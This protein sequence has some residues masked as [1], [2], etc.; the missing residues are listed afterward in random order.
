MENPQAAPRGGERGVC[1]AKSSASTSLS[2]LQPLQVP[3]G[4]EEPSFPS[5]GATALCAQEAE[6][7]NEALTKM[8]VQGKKHGPARPQLKQGASCSSQQP[9]AQGRAFARGLPLLPGMLPARFLAA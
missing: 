9:V 7:R 1:G 3:S 4:Q 8:K 2:P 5:W 6:L